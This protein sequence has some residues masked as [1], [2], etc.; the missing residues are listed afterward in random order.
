MY[1]SASFMMMLRGR[2]IARRSNCNHKD[3]AAVLN[4]LFRKH[5][6][7]SLSVFNDPVTAKTFTAAII[8]VKSPGGDFDEGLY[9]FSVACA[10]VF[11]RLRMLGGTTSTGAY[12]MNVIGWVVHGYFG[13]CMLRLS[14]LI[15]LL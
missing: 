14:R 7:L 4:P 11:A 15:R 3:V 9:Q 2:N 8:E 1:I 12:A 5:P 13:T 6:D 10:G